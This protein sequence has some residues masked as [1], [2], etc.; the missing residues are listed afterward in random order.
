LASTMVSSG[1]CSDGIPRC[2]SMFLERLSRSMVGVARDG[3]PEPGERAR[4]H[5]DSKAVFRRN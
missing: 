5:R 3:N 2:I 4:V 1:S